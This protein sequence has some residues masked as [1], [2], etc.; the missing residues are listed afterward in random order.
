MLVG[1]GLKYIYKELAFTKNII[2]WAKKREKFLLKR[3]RNFFYFA[4]EK[5]EMVEKKVFDLSKNLEATTDENLSLKN[6]NKSIKDKSQY[7]SMQLTQLNDKL[8]VN[9]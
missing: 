1:K 9:K 7:Q 4:F 3:F 6:E 5:R 8:Q 2:D